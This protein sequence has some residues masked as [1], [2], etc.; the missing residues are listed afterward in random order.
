MSESPP[1]SRPT[2]TWRPR[3]GDF[4]TL[5]ERYQIL[6]VL[7]QGGMGTVF[8]AFHTKLK[9]FLAIKTLRVGQTVS[10]DLV[11][12][13]LQE[14][15]LVGQMDHP[16]VVRAT[17]AGEKNGVFYLVMEY[18]NGSDLLRLVRYKG[19]LS[20]LDACELTR[21]AALGLDYIH[22]TVIHRDIKPSNL[23]LT[24]EGI[25]KIL[26]LGLARLHAPDLGGQTLTPQGHVVGTYDYIA[27]EQAA[28]GARVDSRAD[29]YSLGC[30]LFTLLTGRPPY[31]GAAYDSA[32]RKLY[33][34][35]HVPLTAVEAFH[36]IPAELQPVLLRLTAKDPEA[37]YASGRE[38]SEVLTPFAVG[39]RPAQ[40]LSGPEPN[41]EPHLAPLP[42]P[43]PEELSQLVTFA[44]E[45]LASIP[46][47][48]A[49]Q[50]PAPGRRRPFALFGA[51]F[52]V[53][54]LLAG[55]G[56]LIP[57]L[58][59]PFVGD[60]EGGKPSPNGPGKQT[61]GDGT[62]ATG[63]VALDALR[64]YTYHR[65]LA[66]QPLPVGY[67]VEKDPPPWRWD[68]G[69][70]LLE[71][72]GPSSQFFPAWRHVAVALFPRG[73]YHPDTLDG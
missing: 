31:G 71:V 73:R 44:S 38:V 60:Q 11:E 3:A 21:Q 56:V 10:R 69:Q 17:D 45:T 58:R 66:Q 72:K 48:G 24:P 9:R 30:T 27:P 53:C 16:N 22:R 49:A 23:M 39:S 5:L 63:P 14:M 36:S 59:R 52:L 67:R 33:A 15:E 51:G 62:D 6:G 46:T 18:L 29:L 61:N 13:F 68:S 25:V 57:A 65:L 64:T 47:S 26:D 8:Q 34:H 43:L 42:Q 50:A 12:R 55:V 19:R 54:L 40:L 37:R 20:A 70:Q 1:A 7:G 4:P 41:A 2:G 32:A 35:C 28:A